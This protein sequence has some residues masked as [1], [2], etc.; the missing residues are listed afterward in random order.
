MKILAGFMA[1]SVVLLTVAADL[2]RGGSVFAFSAYVPGGDITGHF[3]LFCLLSFFV[4]SWLSRSAATTPRW[5][6]VRTTAFLAIVVAIEELSQAF[7]STRT[8]SLLDL[9]ASLAGLLAGS[10][11]SLWLTRP[12][13]ARGSA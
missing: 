1:V 9:S 12:Q 11:A 4:T 13:P 3:V 2:G 8:F 5:S 6:R 7:I 10:L